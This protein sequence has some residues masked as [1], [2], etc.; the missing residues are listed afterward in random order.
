[1]DSTKSEGMMIRQLIAVFLLVSVALAGLQPVR[2]ASRLYIYG[3]WQPGVNSPEKDEAH[4]PYEGYFALFGAD[5]TY[6]L[7]IFPGALTGQ[8]LVFRLVAGIADTTVIDSTGVYT[9][10]DVTCDTLHYTSLDP[11]AGGGG[12][13]M[14]YH[15]QTL[16]VGDTSVAWDLDSGDVAVVTLTANDTI[17]NPTNLVN[18]RMIRLIIMQDGTGSRVPVWGTHFRWPGDAIPTLTATPDAG[19]GLEF[20]CMNDSLMLFWAFNPAILP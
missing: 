3:N 17:Q 18:G 15:V 8:G 9:T 13:T 4:Y 10:G 5:T 14:W 11:P 2:Y 20:M 12:D 6:S 19:D 16:V 1:M 7:R